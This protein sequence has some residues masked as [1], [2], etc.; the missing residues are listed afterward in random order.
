MSPAERGE[1]ELER[2]QDLEQRIEAYLAGALDLEATR[3]VERE[4]ATPAGAAL[5][6]QALALREVLATTPAGPP[7]GLL[8]RLQA[9]VESELGAAAAERSQ[10]GAAR[11]AL[12]SLRWSMAWLAPAQA[13]VDGLR[14]ALGARGAE[15]EAPAPS[16][17]RPLWRRL[18]RRRK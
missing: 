16:K 17:V 3:E 6:S 8:P 1:P 15:A 4:L 10:V 7:A 18:L 9:A 13:G 12:D 11:I 5:L 14:Y 2:E